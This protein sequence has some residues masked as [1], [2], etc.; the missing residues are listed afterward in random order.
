MLAPFTFVPVHLPFIPA[1]I[2]KSAS[3]LKEGDPAK[4]MKLRAGRYLHW[5]MKTPTFYPFLP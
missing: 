5:T 4:V 3:A 1:A 2:K